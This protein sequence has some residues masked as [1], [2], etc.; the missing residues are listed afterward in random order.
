MMRLSRANVVYRIEDINRASEDGINQEL[1]HD[2]RPY[3]LFKFK[4]GIYC[5]HAWKQ[6]LYRLKKDTEPSDYLLDYKKTGT[7]PDSFQKNPWG[8]K[9]SAIAPNDMKNKGAYP[10]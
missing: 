9:E 10:K 4:G 2:G 5:R 1:G 6:V 7:I 3:N 8:S